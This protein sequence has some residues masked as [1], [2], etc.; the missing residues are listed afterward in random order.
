MAALRRTCFANQ[1]G[2]E[3][4]LRSGKEAEGEVKWD[5]EWFPVWK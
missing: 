5:S 2:L 4:R 1:N 3:S